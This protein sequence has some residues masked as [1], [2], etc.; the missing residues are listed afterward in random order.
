MDPLHELKHRYSFNDNRTG[1]SD[2]ALDNA[3]D[4]IVEMDEVISRGYQE[5]IGLDQRYVEVPRK[6]PPKRGFAYAVA[7]IDR[8]NDT[9]RLSHDGRQRVHD[10]QI[11]GK[12]C[13]HD[14]A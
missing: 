4:L 7:T 12:D 11:R 1:R 8:D 2:A 14:D 3:I 13:G 5:Q 9:M 6:V 10:Q